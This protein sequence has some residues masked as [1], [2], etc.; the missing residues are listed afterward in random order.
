[1]LAADIL[2]WHLDVM[3][4]EDY[5]ERVLKPRLSAEVG[6]EVLEGERHL[7]GIRRYSGWRWR[8]LRDLTLMYWID[9]FVLKELGHVVVLGLPGIA[10]ATDAYVHADFNFWLVA[11]A[12]GVGVYCASVWASF[13]SA[14][15]TYMAWHSTI[16][17]SAWKA[18]DPQGG[19]RAP[20]EG[21]PLLVQA[22][23]SLR[24]TR[25]V[26]GSG[27]SART[28]SSDTIRRWCRGSEWARCAAIVIR[29]PFGAEKRCG[30][31]M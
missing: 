17:P 8:S 30:R 2:H 4:L 19:A 14:A 13:W 24:R 9:P 12:S 10:V 26:L 6:E 28:D 31:T 18:S 20:V 23:G 21:A 11:L 5:T 27:S 16:L 29:R 1:M 3:T 22:D 7:A 15:F 25:S